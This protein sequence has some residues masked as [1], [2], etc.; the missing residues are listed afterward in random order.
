MASN[1]WRT[2]LTFSGPV[3]SCFAAAGEPSPGPGSVV[4]AEDD[5][6][7]TRWL[8]RARN[9]E[10]T[11]QRGLAASFEGLQRNEGRAEANSGA[12]RY[13]RREPETVDPVVDE[14]P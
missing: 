13:G 7:Y 5:I 14:E 9:L 2:A 6:S 10:N 1:I 8:G 11:V 12:D 4:V 3:G